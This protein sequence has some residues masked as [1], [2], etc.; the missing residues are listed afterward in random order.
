MVTIIVAVAENGAIG[1]NNQLLWHLPADMKFFRDTTTGHSIITGRKNYESI[2][3][4][5]RP[6]SNRLNVIVTR[7][8][9]YVAP[10]AVVVHSLEDAI[11]YC[12][13][14]SGNE[15]Y[16]I[17]GGEI[18]KECLEKKLAD[19]MLITHV[20]TAPDADT[21]FKW[22]PEHWIQI[23]STERKA[24]EK[25]PFDLDFTLYKRK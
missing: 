17:G 23:S 22:I 18:Y 14:N 8:K 4:K 20:H 7:Q 1:K 25:N 12:R 16:I 24:D 15:I 3:E 21:F 9:D 19:Q 13:K 5:F 10:G 6:L 11:D 2:P